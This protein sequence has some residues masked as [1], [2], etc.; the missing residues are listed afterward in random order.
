MTDSL[1]NLI[2][3][4]TTEQLFNQ[5]MALATTLGFPT[6]SWQSGGTERARFLLF[7]TMLQ[8]VAASYVP[9][10]AEGGLVDLA[11]GD[12]LT[13]L[14]ASNF[15]KIRNPAS[16]TD[17]YLSFD[18]TASGAGTYAVTANTCYAIMPD[19]LRYYNVNDFTVPQGAILTDILFRSEFDV[20]TSKGLTYSEGSN[21]AIN[22]LNP[23]PGVIVTNPQ[24]T[25]SAVIHSGINNTLS[26]GTG[27]VTPS[28]SPINKYFVIVRIDSSG[29]P[30]AATWSYSLDGNQFVSAGNVT[31]I[32]LIDGETDTGILATLSAGSPLPSFI[33]GETYVFSTIQSWIITQGA[34]E[35]S[36]DSLRQRCIDTIPSLSDTPTDGFYQLLVTSCPGVGSQVTQVIVQA[37]G[38]VGDK[39]N[40]VIAG[41]DG[42]LTAPT[43]E[44]VQAWVDPRAPETEFPVVSSPGALAVGIGAT[45]TVAN[46]RYTALFGTTGYDGLIGQVLTLNIE[47]TAIN[48]VIRISTIIEIIKQIPG[49]I[50]ITD[51]SIND[52][53]QN[54]ILGTSTTFQLAF[55]DSALSSL[56][57]ITQ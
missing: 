23:L 50:D 30:G 52:L 31:A 38:Y 9:L 5:M 47:T 15:Q 27:S 35:E 24:Q 21:Q 26:R 36:D 28:G 17:G 57:W 1:S 45:I 48:G 16:A 10:T 54:L 12:W 18:T 11:T 14:A 40:V 2:E 49:V 25:F 4:V 32:E 34:D 39:V 13:Q 44:L 41:P 37:D 46:N 33:I 29:E 19:N 3:P 53:A 8:D 20:D 56:T 42:P 7:A 6:S 22:L 43:V 55:F 51:V